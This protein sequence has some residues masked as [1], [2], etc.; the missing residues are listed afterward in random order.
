MLWE[1]CTQH[2]SKSEK[3]SSGHRTGKGQFPFQIAKAKPKNVQTTTQLHS[4]HM[5]AKQCSKFSKQGFNSPWTKN[6][7]ILKL[8]LEK[9]EEPEIQLPTSVGSQKK[10]QHSRK[11]TTSA[12]LTRLKPLTMW[13]TANCG[14]FFKR[15]EYQTTLPASWETCMEIKKQHLE[16]DTEQWIG[17]K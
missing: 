16:P 3:L 14:K 10:Q 5:L 11:T 2:A 15:W 1:C 4:S 7:Q 9:P 13:I 8:D 17:Y 6:L 12:S